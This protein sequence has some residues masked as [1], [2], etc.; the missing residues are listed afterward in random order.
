MK[1]GRPTLY[2]EDMID[3]A[4]KYIEDCPDFV[5]SLVGLSMV[6][7]VC[8]STLNKWKALDTKDLDE[9]KYPRF[10]DFLQILSKLHDFQKQSA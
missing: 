1:T 7:N 10:E 6:L 8:E 9:E 5:P 4:I 3:T 2:N